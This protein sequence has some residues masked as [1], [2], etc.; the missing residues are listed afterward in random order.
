MK[1]K[2]PDPVLRGI[3]I[4]NVSLLFYPRLVFFIYFN[5]KSF[6]FFLCVVKSGDMKSEIPGT[7]YLIIFLETDSSCLTAL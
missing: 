5:M 6:A 7:Q 2:W 3:G 4:N 1:L